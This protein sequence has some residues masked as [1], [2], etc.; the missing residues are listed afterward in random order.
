MP[1]LVN[2]EDSEEE[3]DVVEVRDVDSEVLSEALLQREMNK[4]TLRR[5]EEKREKVEVCKN[6]SLFSFFWQ[7]ERKEYLLWSRIY[8]IYFS[9]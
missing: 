4:F 7:Q 5:K 9:N 8:N 6:S 3:T 1:H 2:K